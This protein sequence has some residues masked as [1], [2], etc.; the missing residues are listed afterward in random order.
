MGHCLCAWLV[1]GNA[2]NQLVNQSNAQHNQW[3]AGVQLLCVQFLMCCTA[4][5]VTLPHLQRCLEQQCLYFSP[6][7]DT[8]IIIVCCC[9]LVSEAKRLVRNIDRWWGASGDARST[10]TCSSCGWR[11]EYNQRSSSSN[12]R[13]T[14]GAWRHGICPEWFKQ[15]VKTLQGSFVCDW[16]GFCSEYCT[17]SLAFALNSVFAYSAH[18]IVCVKIITCGFLFCFCWILLTVSSVWDS[19][20][21]IALPFV[22]VF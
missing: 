18:K 11:C 9:C 8:V 21:V 14:A 4:D 2:F 1:R 20:A 13:S 15:L 5:A 7:H 16:S 17:I 22:I 10:G 19:I 3:Y 12:L 6:E